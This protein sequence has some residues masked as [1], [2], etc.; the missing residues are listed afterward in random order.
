MINL[1]KVNIIYFLKL[2]VAICIILFL[3]YFVEFDEIIKI[4]S[5]IDYFFLG[6]V[7]LLLVLNIYFQF[8]KWEV[9]CNN[10]LNEYD[11]SKIV[12]SL[13]IGI[14]AG[15]FTPMKSGE[16][17]AR[18]LE[19]KEAS[20]TK[21]TLATMVDKS[22]TFITIFVFG[23]PVFIFSLEK[24]V[25]AG[26]SVLVVSTSI[27]IILVSLI[28]LVFV[29]RKKIKLNSA[30]NK[31][32]KKVKEFLES[33]NSV[34]TKVIIKT[35]LY[36]ILHLAVICFQFLFLLLAFNGSMNQHFFQIPLLMFFIQIFIPPLVLGE[37]G[38]RESAAVY[39][40][41][42]IGLNPAIGFNAAMFLF[43]INFILPSLLTLLF[44]FRKK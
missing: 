6:A 16:Y 29:N 4:L 21:V 8:K 36:A 1:K 10:T 25:S 5:Q 35:F 32:T 18:A 23:G 11:S 31:I 19:L 37:I 14:S 9:L 38:I 22:F 41:D 17:F 42:K 2:L 28:A 40:V 15:M 26:T 20:S 3:I 34:S 7:I 30:K 12:K 33:I 39:L 44:I 27:F 13:L 24:F 43:L